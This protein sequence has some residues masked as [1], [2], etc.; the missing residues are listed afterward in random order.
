MI[1]EKISKTIERKFQNQLNKTRSGS[2]FPMN[3]SGALQKSLKSEVISVGGFETFKLRGLWY[4]SELNKGYTTPIN[5]QSGA[6]SQP[7][8]G[9]IHGLTSWLMSK[10]GLSENRAKEMAFAIA[11]SKIDANSKNPGSSFTP[12]NKGWIDEIKD[13]VDNEIGNLINIETTQ[14]INQRVDSALSMKI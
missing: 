12:S 10:K 3:T 9:Y 4:G 5:L 7:G 2:S 6:G 13:D 11:N 8:S 14:T 1:L